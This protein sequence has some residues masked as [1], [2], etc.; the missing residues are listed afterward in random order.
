MFAYTRAGLSSPAALFIL[1]GSLIGSYVNIPLFYLQSHPGVSSQVIDYF[2]VQYVV[3]VADWQGTVRRRECRRLR[4]SRA[5][6]A[7]YPDQI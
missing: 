6:L 4:H 5:D 3:P 7:L 2:G 1:F